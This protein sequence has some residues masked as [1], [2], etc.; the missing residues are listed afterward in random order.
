MKPILFIL[1][2]FITLSAFSQQV[3]YDYKKVLDI[4]TFTVN[5]DNSYIFNIVTPSY[6]DFQFVWASLDQ[7]DASIKIQVSLD[8][9]NFD[10]YPNTDSL[11]LN[12]PNGSG[13]I[14]DM[15][16]GTS[17]KHIK[18]NIDSGTCTSGTL[19]IYGNITRKHP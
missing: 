16:K 5:S 17:A 8:G 3:D 15:H 13:F 4:P 7:T 1:S 12:S 11:L 10:D 14:R 6:L 19:K 2:I 18:I 9:T